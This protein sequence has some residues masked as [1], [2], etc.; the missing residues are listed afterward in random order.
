MSKY[1]ERGKAVMNNNIQSARFLAKTIM[2]KSAI[3]SRASK[4]HSDE[5]S[6]K[7]ET[8]KATGSK[9]SML[10]SYNKSKQLKL[11][12]KVEDSTADLKDNI[13]DIFKL[14]QST[15]TENADKDREKMDSFIESFV[16]DYNTVVTSLGDLSGSLNNLFVNQV[17]K[18][19]ESYAKELEKVGIT[20][21]ESGE[22]KIDE[23]VFKEASYDDIKAV[24][25]KEDGYLSE[26]NT[27]FDLI[28]KSAAQSV[29]SLDRQYGTSTYD[30][31]G[32]YYDYNNSLYNWWDF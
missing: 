10:E 22:L 5:S 18:I 11:Y 28:N 24:F 21:S 13:A 12:E 30:K 31:S 27:K 1:N 32:N 8:K 23:D 3:R 26:L 2:M 17:G 16:S 20:I 9:N 7:T 14:S 15:D 25:G 29:E 19:T 6:V 4:L